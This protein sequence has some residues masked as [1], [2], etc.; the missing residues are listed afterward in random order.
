MNLHKELRKDFLV[1]LFSDTSSNRDPRIQMRVTDFAKSITSNGLFESIVIVKKKEDLLNINSDK[2]YILD[3]YIDMEDI[4]IEVPS[5]GLDIFGFSLEKAGLFSTADNYT[6]FKGGNV[7][8]IF[9]TGCKFTVTGVGSKVLGCTSATGFETME[10]SRVNFY[11]CSSIGELNNYR[12]ILMDNVGLFGGTPNLTLSGAMNGIKVNNYIVRNVQSG[13][14]ALWEEGTNLSFSG[15]VSMVVNVDLSAPVA[16]SDFT[17]SNLINSDSFQI[18]NSLFTRGGVINNND[19]TIIPNLP[20]TRLCVSY[21]NNDGI[22][23]K[24]KRAELRLSVETPT[25]IALVDTY[26]KLNG[27]WTAENLVDFD[28]PANGQLRYL[29]SR[30]AN[31]KVTGNVVLESTANDTVDYQVRILRYNNGTPFYEDSRHISRVVNNLQGGIRDVA[32]VQVED[33]FVL[34]QFDIVEQWV[35]NKTAVNNITGELDSFFI[36]LAQ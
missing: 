13:T 20:N 12:Q 1:S 22:Y 3:G 4:E 23:N 27:T 8:N 21:K 34:N 5:T 2:V 17:E 30:P 7:G 14:Y 10:L 24:F 6:M 18:Q 35:G 16:F 15:R 25:A 19:D 9:F 33:S 31:M 28:S 26:Y 36:I 32:Y 11:S 29:S